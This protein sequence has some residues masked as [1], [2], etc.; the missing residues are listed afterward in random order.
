VA[1]GNVAT[2]GVGIEPGWVDDDTLIVG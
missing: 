2:F 1:T